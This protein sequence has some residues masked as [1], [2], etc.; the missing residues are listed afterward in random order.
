M[1]DVQTRLRLFCAVELPETVKALV[2]EYIKSL[3]T[4][5]PNVRASWERTEKLHLTLKF[6]GDVEENRLELLRRA[7]TLAAARHAA[8]Q[9]SIAGTGLFPPK[10]APRVLWLGICD[11]DEGLLR[12]QRDLEKECET[13]GFQREARTF[14]PH[15]T[16]ARLRSPEGAR[17]LT[18]CHTQ[19]SFETQ[20]FTVSELVII[21]SELL[22]GGS[23]YTPFSH[24]ALS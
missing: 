18:D 1:T 14:R 17:A 4:Q 12:L 15:L 13:E 23:R 10:R 21:R 7:A 22:P 8:F 20:R 2:G 6:I 24:H 5:F 3:R 11:P 16:I 9:I 19:S